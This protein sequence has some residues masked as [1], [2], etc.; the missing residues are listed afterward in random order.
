MFANFPQWLIASYQCNVTEHG[1]R[2]KC[3]TLLYF[4]HA[5]TINVNNFKRIIGNNLEVLSFDVLH[6]FEYNLF[7]CKF[8]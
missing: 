1:V 7:N 2:K 8:T 5:E 3:G 4:H 6:L